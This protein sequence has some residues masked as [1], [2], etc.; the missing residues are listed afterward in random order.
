MYIPAHCL[1]VPPYRFD[2]IQPRSEDQARAR[3]D[4]AC[5]PIQR[6]DHRCCRFEGDGGELHRY[7]VGI[8]AVVQLSAELPNF[9]S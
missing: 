7:V 2:V 6:W 4:D 5:F 8:Q 1:P 3:Y 9:R